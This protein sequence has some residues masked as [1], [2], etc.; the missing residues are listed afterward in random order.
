M[1]G[2]K[3]MKLQVPVLRRV[4][5]RIAAVAAVVLTAVGAT[6]L[7]IG[8]SQAV[9][10]PSLVSDVSDRTDS[11]NFKNARARCPA[12]LKVYGAAYKVTN[13]LGSVAV[14]TLQPDENLTSVFV[15]AQEV[16]PG[17][18]SAWSVTAQAICGPAIENLQRIRGSLDS[19]VSARK[20]ISVRCPGPL[21][22]YGGGFAIPNGYGEV[23]MQESRALRTMD[24]WFVSGF[25]DDN[26]PSWGLTG[27]AICGGR[28]RTQVAVIEEDY[29]LDSNSPKRESIHCPTGTKLHGVGVIMAGAHG[30]VLI[31]D[32]APATSSLQATTVKSF[33][34]DPT[35]NN[36]FSTAQAV[37]AS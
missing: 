11:T 24:A 3:I 16:A 31:E 4:D 19:S 23:F 12:P 9:A 27:Y 14:N 20:D 1:K 26:P 22:V 35:P 28:A 25:A 5:R 29:D 8:P 18:T 21:A 32:M 33:E 37:C 7:G 34:N 13:G 17:I 30:D 36:W 10:S 6:I 15:E 2:R